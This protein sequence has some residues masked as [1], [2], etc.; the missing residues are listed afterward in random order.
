MNG[1]WGVIA[2]LTAAFLVPSAC[3][4]AEL[5]ASPVQQLSIHGD[6]R[7]HCSISSP[8]NVDFGDLSRTGLQAD[9]RL[10]LNCNV[11]FSLNVR[12]DR[13]GLT[14]SE[15]PMGQGPY[16]GS[17]PYTLDFTIPTSSPSSSVINERINGRDLVGGKSISSRGAIATEG[18]GVRVTLGQ[19]DG[20]AGLLA[21]DYGETITITIASI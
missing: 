13:G 18:M 17:I 4:G 5:D 1:L 11:P 15:F 6:V 2:A 3:A 10:G 21:G 16:A 14:N 7:S 9:L 20:D 8:G 12:A 19:A